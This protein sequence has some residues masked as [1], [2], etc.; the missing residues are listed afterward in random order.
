M[1]S[2][3]SALDTQHDKNSC[4][5]QESCIYD[6]GTMAQVERF[7]NWAGKLKLDLADVDGIGD[8]QET[9]VGAA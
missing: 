6:L 5:A 4:F 7:Q 9:M 2:A 3:C 8:R 1:Q